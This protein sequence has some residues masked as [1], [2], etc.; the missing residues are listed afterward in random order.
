MERRE[1]DWENADAA[2]MER[3]DLWERAAM[4]TAREWQC[5]TGGGNSENGIT[6]QE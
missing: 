2:E 6:A 1:G 4:S 5:G 3:E